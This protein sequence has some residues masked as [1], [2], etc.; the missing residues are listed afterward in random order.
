[1][2][3]DILKAIA[4]AL[5]AFPK[6]KVYIDDM[7]QGIELPCFT[8]ALAESTREKR[9]HGHYK[10]MQPV[11]VTYLAED[12]AELRQ[13]YELLPFVL[14]KITVNDIAVFGTHITIAIDA[15]RKALHYTSNYDYTVAIEQD[16]VRMQDITFVGGTK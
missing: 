1:M 6:A 13:V 8:L 10:V 3:N 16:D 15:D 9:L 14:Y 7:Q 2:V 11:T 4:V 12:E 5:K